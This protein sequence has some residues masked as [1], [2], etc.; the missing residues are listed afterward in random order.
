MRWK[1]IGVLDRAMDWFFGIF[2]I[3]LAIPMFIIVGSV[4]WFGIFATV[5][6]LVSM[7]FGGEPLLH[8]P[9][10]SR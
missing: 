9:V 1:E 5:I 6:N 7:F 4:L 3:F 2:V 10:V 8:L